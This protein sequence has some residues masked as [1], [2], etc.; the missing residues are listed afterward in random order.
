MTLRSPITAMLWELWRVT[1]VEAAWKLAWGVVVPLIVWIV[2][3]RFESVTDSAASIA[4][5]LLYLPHI[6][7]WLSFA[8]LS[9]A[10]TGFPLHLHYSRPI[11]TALMVGLPMAYLTSLT[12]A[13]YL[14]SIFLLSATAYPHP[15]LP[16]AAWL[17]TLN[18]AITAI[19][20]STRS[21]VIVMLGWTVAL[22]V[23]GSAIGSRLDS[24]P[25]GVDYPLP[26]YAVMALIGLVCFGVATAS[27]GRQRRGDVSAPII[28][29][30]GSGLWEWLI[31]RFRFPCPTSSAAW[32]QV[33]MD[34]K[35]N[36]LPLLTLGVAIAFVMVLVSAV[37]GP[38]DAAWNAD[39]D[40]KCPIEECFWARA[41]PPLFT[42]LALFLVSV[43]GGNA[44]GIRRRQGR[45]CMSAFQATQAHGTAQL[46]LLK[47]LVKSACVLAAFLAIGVGAWISIPLL[48]DPVFIQMWNVPLS[49][50]LPALTRAVA[51]LSGYEQLSLVVVPVV[52]VVI[53]VATLAVLGALRV[54]YSRRVDIAAL[55]VG[56]YGLVLVWLAVGVRVDPETTSRLHLD[57]VYRAMEWVAAAAIVFTTVY[58]FRSGFAEHVLTIRYASGAAVV[59]AAFG[60]AWLTVL[61]VAGVQ[62]SGL[63]ATNAVSIGW[64]ALLPL[65][66][67]AVA[68]WS[69][70]RI[71][72]T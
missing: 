55:L 39:P 59:S 56:L 68:P 33:W 27:V 34:L 52:G 3:Q 21:I 10:S 4:R 12:F 35:A 58:A 24:F 57:V 50:R 18:V 69:L 28:R 64:P 6:V 7:G 30:P 15:L 19:G 9:G 67:S 32:A 44:F 40:V 20:F 16:A 43:L 71:R 48:G 41:A 53:W 8:A 42:P 29:T 60:A 5:V 37:S 70:S 61:H 36:A 49:S 46:A 72:H 62:L 11:R 14:V 25:K 38:I 66:A 13:I 1:R 22:F 63:S 54:R 26:D 65:M 17:A 51:T 45:A 31:D 23:G 47:V 2:S